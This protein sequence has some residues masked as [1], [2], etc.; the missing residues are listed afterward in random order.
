MIEAVFG[1]VIGTILGSFSKATADRINNKESL[2]GRSYCQKCKTSLQV[3]DL[4]PI[5]SYL[6]LRGRCRYCKTN[7]PSGVFWTEVVV[8]LMGALIFYVFIP[9]DLTF[10]NNLWQTT[11]V[12]ADILFKLFALCVVTI[13]FWTDLKTGLIP[14]KVT[15]PAISI[16]FVFQVIINGLHSWGFYQNLLINP[17]GKYLLPGY[18]NYLWDN[19]TRIWLG[20]GVSVI[21][22]VISTLFFVL[23]IVVTRG[24]GMGWGDV[25]YVLLLGLLLGYPTIIIAVFLAFLTGAIISIGLILLGKKHFG[26]T[27]PFGPFLGLGAILALLWGNLL[28][29]LYF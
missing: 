28:I 15:Y 25:K 16:A 24:K 12:V 26:Q 14:D 22:A 18:S 21:A 13:I 20:F 1:F 2:G 5:F 23:L 7:I 4:F 11:F 17:L 9:P 19:L 8:G 29:N 27:I 3:Q 10:L 6:L